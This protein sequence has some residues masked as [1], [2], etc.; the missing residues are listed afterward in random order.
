MIS[1]ELIRID[2]RGTVHGARYIGELTNRQRTPV[3]S[4]ARLSRDARFGA[5]AA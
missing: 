4:C 2:K 5:E 3:C 1:D